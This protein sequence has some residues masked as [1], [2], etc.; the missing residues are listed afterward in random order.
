MI[1]AAE[2]VECGEED[3]KFTLGPNSRG[4]GYNAYIGLAED[5]TMNF[6]GRGRYESDALEALDDVLN[7]RLDEARRRLE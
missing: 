4:P 2:G 1:F 7:Q 6:I 5:N 3:L